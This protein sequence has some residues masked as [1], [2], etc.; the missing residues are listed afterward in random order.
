MCHGPDR[1]MPAPVVA[2]HTLVDWPATLR[3]LETQAW[4]QREIDTSTHP[5]P[6]NWKG[7]YEGIGLDS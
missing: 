4:L 2:G 1:L 3:Q 7:F 6:K 5:E